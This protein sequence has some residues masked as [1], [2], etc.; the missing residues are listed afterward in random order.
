MFT[1]GCKNKTRVTQLKNAVKFILASIV[2]II[3]ISFA[4]ACSSSPAPTADNAEIE[5]IRAY[6][7]PATQTTLQGLSENSLAKYIQYGDPQFK[8]AVTQDVFNQAY[9]QISSKLGSFESITFL[10]AEPKDGYTIVHYKAKY[11]GGE[12]GVR[13]VFNQEHQVSGQWFE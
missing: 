6:A 1:S 7:D 5:T 11:A 13:M 2:S 8:A 3:L 4:V 9:T 12:V 10:K